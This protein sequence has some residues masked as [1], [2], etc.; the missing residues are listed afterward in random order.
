MALKISSISIIDCN[1]CQFYFVLNVSTNCNFE[2]KVKMG[3]CVSK[4]LPSQLVL[5]NG[6][7][8]QF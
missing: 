4:K 6:P 7:L 5:T 8:Q 1:F 3:I 2:K